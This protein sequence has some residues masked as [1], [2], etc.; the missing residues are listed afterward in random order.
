[1]AKKRISEVMRSSSCHIE[2]KDSFCQPTEAEKIMKN[3][4]CVGGRRRAACKVNVSTCETAGKIEIYD[5][6]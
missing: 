4:S 3:R 2:K 1:M 5:V 6:K